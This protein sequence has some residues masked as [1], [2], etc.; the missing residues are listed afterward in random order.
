MIVQPSGLTRAEIIAKVQKGNIAGLT[1]LDVKAVQDEM[2]LREKAGSA[3]TNK[4]GSVRRKPG[5][6]KGWKKLRGGVGMDWDERSEG[7]SVGEGTINGDRIEKGM[8]ADAEIAA[9]LGDDDDPDGTFTPGG[10][11]AKKAKPRVSIKKRR[12]ESDSG[13][14]EGSEFDS[15]DDRLGVRIP[16]ISGAKKGKST[17]PI[18]L[19]LDN[20][21][22]AAATA[23]EAQAE[24]V[25]APN[26]H[27]PRG[28]SETEARLRLSL[29]EDLERVAW[30]S[31]CRDIPRVS[32]L[33]I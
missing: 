21:L 7:T 24:P 12:L 19:D 33:V 16:K 4:D 8:E 3:P 28:V 30:A 10:G 5:P 32:P 1:E 2:W 23:M 13:L 22:D 11:A 20:E 26:T 6:A 18:D 15:E 14:P 17:R 29:V 27:D 9:L 31:I 25:I